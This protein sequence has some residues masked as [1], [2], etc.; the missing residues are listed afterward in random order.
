M[1]NKHLAN[2]QNRQPFRGRHH[3]APGTRRQ[4]KFQA[5]ALFDSPLPN[6]S[7]TPFLPLPPP[8]SLSL[9]L[10]LCSQ[11]SNSRREERSRKR[12]A[13]EPNGTTATEGNGSSSALIFLGTGCSSA[14]PNAMCLI[15]PSDPPCR[16]CSQSLLLPPDQNPNYRSST[17]ASRL[18]SLLFHVISELA[19]DRFVIRSRNVVCRCEFGFL[20]TWVLRLPELLAFLCCCPL[21]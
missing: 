16:V 21:S 6:V 18:V 4:I 3:P 5:R 2:G 17:S 13:M 11:S 8:A 12:E 15:Q 10:S 9:S 19:C 14:V 1:E 7:F 20:G